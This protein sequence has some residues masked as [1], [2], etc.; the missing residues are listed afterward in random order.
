MRQ[1]FPTR[2]ARGELQSHNPSGFTQR[3][4]TASRDIPLRILAK[5]PLYV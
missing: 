2:V 5:S 4:A 3:M 1:Q